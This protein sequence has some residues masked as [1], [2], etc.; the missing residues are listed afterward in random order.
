MFPIS[1]KNK[2][3]LNY[4]FVLVLVFFSFAVNWN[5]A[6]YGIFPI[7]TFL[8]YDSSFRI[9]KGEYPVKDYWIVSG[10]LV[11]F[12]QAF[13]FKIGEV[14]WQAYIFHSSLFNVVISLF[15]FFLLIELN[16][17]KI[18]AFF[19]AISIAI[20]AY[21]VSGTP[22][23]DMHSTYFCLLATYLI[24]LAIKKPKKNYIWGLTVLFF[25]LAFLSK[26][27]PTVYLIILYSPIIFTHLIITRNF[28]AIK[29]IATTLLIV[30]L[31][32]YLILELLKIDF[33]LFLLQYIYFPQSIGSDRLVNFQFTIEDFFNHYKFILAPLLLLIF[34]G[35]KSF[36]K[37]KINFYSKDFINSLILFSLCL[38]LIVNQILTKNQIYIYFLI[39][40]CFGFLQIQIEKSKMNFKKFLKYLLLF[41][42]IFATTKYHLRFNED[43]KFHELENVDFSKAIGAKEL[44]K[45]LKGILWISP[46]FPNDP[47]DEIIFLKEIRSEIEN[48]N[49]KIMV[50]THYSFLDSITLNNLNSPSRTHTVD[51]ASIPMKNNKYFRDYKKYIEDKIVEK[52]IKQI[53]FL[54]FE[55]LSTEIIS[56]YLKQDCYT[57]SQDKIFIKFKVEKNCYN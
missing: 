10:F 55:K 24:F 50:L 33:K 53:Y 12:I 21:P 40:L 15:T 51:G 37:N 19:Y 38:G 30:I 18:Y 6:K 9:L 57:Q 49:S 42:V 7:D 26:Q 8:H 14:N 27:V 46:Y 2:I 43:R 34:I 25:A 54:K 3:I 13:F 48:T 1:R 32:F 45:S 16:L 41:V 47:K 4:I 39:P 44:D 35:S 20:L 22:F 56:Q 31:S 5:Y 11:D 52:N 17:N 36:N 29:V 23:V 28:Q